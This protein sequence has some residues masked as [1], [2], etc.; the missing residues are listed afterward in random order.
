MANQYSLKE[1]TNLNKNSMDKSRT[2]IENLKIQAC[3]LLACRVQPPS[4]IIKCLE[5]CFCLYNIIDDCVSDR[6]I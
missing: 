2:V 4:I 1:T 3:C 6:H 5:I